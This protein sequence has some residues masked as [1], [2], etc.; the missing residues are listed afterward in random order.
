M[1]ESTDPVRKFMARPTMSPPRPSSAALL[2]RQA[3]R[4]SAARS[5]ADAAGTG[6]LAIGHNHPEV[7]SALRSTLDS[8]APL[9]VLT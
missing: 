8:G 7:I 9:H 5:Y 4:E 2:A 6:T 1:I 3:E